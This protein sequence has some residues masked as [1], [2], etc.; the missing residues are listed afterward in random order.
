MPPVMTPILPDGPLGD[1]PTLPPTG[2]PI[3]LPDNRNGAQR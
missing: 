2:R 3:M 1:L